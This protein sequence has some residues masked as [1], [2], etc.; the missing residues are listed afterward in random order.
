[1]PSHESVTPALK[2]PPDDLWT[3]VARAAAHLDLI[4]DEALGSMQHFTT[5]LWL[6]DLLIRL[7][8]AFVISVV[9]RVDE[10]VARRLWFTLVRSSGA[11]DWLQA[12]LGS[13]ERLTPASLSPTVL[14]IARWPLS[15]PALPEER[16]HFARAADPLAAL[17][18]GLQ[19][20]EAPSV[21]RKPSRAL[22]FDLLVQVRN[23]TVHGAYD[24]RFYEDHV[25]VVTSAVE[26]LLR[27][28]PLWKV[29]LL[30]MTS[31]R[32]GRLLRG[33]APTRA[34]ELDAAFRRDDVVFQVEDEAWPAGPI[35]TIRGDTTFV[36]NGSWRTADASAEFLCHSV[37]A[38]EPGQGTARIEL[39]TLARP[40]LPS[41]GQ[42]VDGQ[43]RI[44]QVLGEGEDAV[45]YLARHTDE[46]VQYVLKA[47][48]EAKE[49]F[50]QR[51][52]EF[53]ALRRIDHPGIP[54]VHE[55]HPWEAP[56]HL[57]FDH[58]PGAQ[59]RAKRDE[60]AGNVTAVS[61]LGTQLADALTA[62]HEAGYVHRDV[63]PD[64]ILL[65]DDPAKHVRLVDFDLVA[66]IGTIGR[67]GTSLYRPPEA[68]T[69]LPR[70]T[71]P[72]RR[73]PEHPRPR[74]L[75][76]PPSP[77]PHG[78]RLPR[79]APKDG[80]RGNDRASRGSAPSQP[81]VRTATRH[82]NRRAIWPKARSRT[83]RRQPRP[84]RDLHRRP[85]PSWHASTGNRGPPSP[86]RRRR[87]P[88]IMG[89]PPAGTDGRAVR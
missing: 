87:H 64:N 82:H 62:I 29:D 23:K 30:Y 84:R 71:R 70:R 54:R 58:V 80:H 11:G 35:L 41:V 63:A 28:S 24:A 83:S 55:I 76:Q 69:S 19:H 20:N 26:W 27:E 38:S 57:R 17:A 52:V 44:L 61:S 51:R 25:D 31:S 47:F 18:A 45:V 1:M 59:L 48:R 86:P 22:L 85:L 13:R 78:A 6:G 37:A 4:A 73:G 3:P 42:I 32:R 39:P 8:A 9:A 7:Y 10:A 75:A 16:Q 72:P 79:S 67:A 2:P 88:I 53:E 49:S 5:A 89:H 50:D 60:L 12:M 21:A 34:R 46:D 43:Y 74:R 15:A 77:L 40:P 33:L 68:E 65:P 14:E 66:P 36:A 81:P 56:F